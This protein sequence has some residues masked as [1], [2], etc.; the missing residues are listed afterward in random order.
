ML[1]KS[2]D[3]YISWILDLK[4]KIQQSQIKAAF[5]INSALKEMYWDLG[6]EIANRNFE[7]TDGFSFFFKAEQRLT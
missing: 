2:N 5:Q 6:K 7:N 1:H 4:H 3:H